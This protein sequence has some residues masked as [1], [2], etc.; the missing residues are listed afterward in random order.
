MS[1]ILIKYIS[2]HNGANTTVT[3]PTSFNE[4]H[5][6][7]PN[8]GRRKKT[9]RSKYHKRYP[10][11]PVLGFAHRHH[12]E[13]SWVAMVHRP[14]WHIDMVFGAPSIWCQE[15]KENYIHLDCEQKTWVRLKPCETVKDCEET[16]STSKCKYRN[17]WK[18]CNW[19]AGWLALQPKTNNLK[20]LEAF[21]PSA[22]LEKKVHTGF[23][24]SLGKGQHV[25]TPLCT[26]FCKNFLILLGDAPL[27]CFSPRFKTLGHMYLPTFPWS[28]LRG[29][30]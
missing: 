17:A 2:Y 8:K 9:R 6:Q 11:L 29:G 24:G 21:V 20:I 12:R 18:C 1:S 23:M 16:L 27:R 4:I 10:S 30:P 28:V 14:T 26:S 13:L 15:A 22:T 3:T 19:K 5:M 7:Q 25:A